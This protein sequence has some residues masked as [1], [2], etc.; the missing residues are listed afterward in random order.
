[1]FTIPATQVGTDHVI[2]VFQTCLGAIADAISVRP[3]GTIFDLTLGAAP[4]ISLGSANS[5]TGTMSPIVMEMTDNGDGTWDGSND[6]AVSIILSAPNTFD[7]RQ[8]ISSISIEGTFEEALMTFSALKGKFSG[9][10]VTKNL[11]TPDMPPA[12]LWSTFESGS[13]TSIAFAGATGGA[14]LTMILAATC[15]TE[16]VTAPMRDGQPT[17]P[18]TIRIEDT[19]RSTGSGLVFAGIFQAADWASAH[20]NQTSRDTDKEALNA[21]L[22]AG[23]PFFVNKTAVGKGTKASVDTPTGTVQIGEVGFTVDIKGAVS[24]GKVREAILVSGLRFPPGVVCDWAA[25]ILPQKVSL[26]VQVTNFDAAAGTIETLGAFDLADGM[27]D[28]TDSDKV[29]FYKADFY[30]QTSTR[31]AP[32]R[33][34]RSPFSRMAL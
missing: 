18:F 7:L 17:M 4:Q 21:I 12:Q 32:I 11:V 3:T 31:Q 10:K 8:D 19:T 14:D 30:R 34:S 9:V 2:A 15:V 28:T 26:D 5:L 6:Q 33:K 20:L 13:F 27:A 24:E 1:M 22:T 16:I 25:P 29:D 23:L